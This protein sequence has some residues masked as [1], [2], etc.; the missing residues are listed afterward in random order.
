[1]AAQI[2]KLSRGCFSLARDQA[3]SD[4][5][6][7]R[8]TRL[9]MVHHMCGHYSWVTIAQLEALGES[10]KCCC[11]CTE[12]MSLEHIGN[13]I[14]SVQRFV[15]VR[16]G[17]AA[18]FSHRNRLEGADISDVFLFHCISPCKG[19]PFDSPFSWFLRDSKSG[20]SIETNGCPV[21][22][23]RVRTGLS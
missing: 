19:M 10:D 20:Y 1:L 4:K 6:W 16:S 9:K 5:E 22:E 12:P 11:Y 15:E 2:E 23:A 21:C 8:Y 3:P 14:A 18:F 7:S 13:D 17:G